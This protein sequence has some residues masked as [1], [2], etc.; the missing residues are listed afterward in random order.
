MKKLIQDSKRLTIVQVISNYPN[1]QPVPSIKGGT[2]K[3]VFELTEELV[4]RGHKVY[5][6]AALGSRSKANLITYPK[7]FR[8]KNIAGFV[9]RKTPERADIIHDHTFRSALGQANLNIPTLCTIHIPDRRRVKYPVY[10][11][12][13]ARQLMGNNKGFYV[14]NGINTSEYEFSIEK[15][16]YLL[17]IGRIIRDKGI[18]QAIEVA[19]KTG[20]KLIIAGPVKD[21]HFFRREVKPRIQK[22]AKIRYVG[23]VGGKL[24]QQLFKHAECVLF[25]T[26][27]EEQFGLVMIESMACG[28]PVLALRNGAVPEVLSEFPNLICNTV[29]EM[30]VK[31]RQKNYPPPLILRKYVIKRFT[32]KK[33]TDSY[34]RIYQDV[35]QKESGNSKRR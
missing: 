17:F 24:K 3:I 4:R 13:S 12:K 2:E 18:L 6:F 33:M 21:L 28:T 35:I 19:E 7:G 15:H 27:L 25:P 30:I 20:K 10:V 23:P 11:S 32:N 34:L 26:L 29:S 1:A 22:N 16:G 31:V 8:H 14:Y 5:L 9:I